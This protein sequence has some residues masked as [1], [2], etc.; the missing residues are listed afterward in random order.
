MRIPTNPDDREFFYLDLIRKCQVSQNER[1]GDYNTLRSFYL[2][3]A[4]P[5]ESP[6]L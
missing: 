3:G 1:K 4:G 6:A 5:D 2:F